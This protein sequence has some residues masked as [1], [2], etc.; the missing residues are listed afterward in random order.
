M[1]GRPLMT[2]GEVTRRFRLGQNQIYKPLVRAKLGLRAIRLGKKLLFDP[3]HVDQL[4]R[5][6]EE[7]LPVMPSGGDEVHDA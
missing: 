7:A 4:L 1:T 5:D 3:D 6:S 2:A